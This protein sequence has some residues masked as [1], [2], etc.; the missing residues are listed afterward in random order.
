MYRT[1]Y[2]E[3]EVDVTLDDFDD[4]DLIDELERRG[5]GFEVA[6]QTTTD[7]LQ[8]IYEKRRLGRDYQQELDELIYVAIG[9]IV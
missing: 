6:G 3:V 2:K 5:R 9:R 7:L 4:H 8:Q 1:I